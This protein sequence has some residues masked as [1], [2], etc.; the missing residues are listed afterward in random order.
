MIA[1]TSLDKTTR[2]WDISGK[3]IAILQ[4]FNTPSF[5]QISADRKYIVAFP[6]DNSSIFYIWDANGKLLSKM[7]KA[8]EHF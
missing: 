7:Q 5:I 4:N 6:E 2:I 3:S 1:S 8:N